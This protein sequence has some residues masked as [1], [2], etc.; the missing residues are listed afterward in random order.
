MIKMIKKIRSLKSRLFI[1]LAVFGPGIVTAVADNDAAGVATYSLVGAKFG[2]SIL[3]VLFVVTV[4]LAITHLKINDAE[5]ASI[6]P[7]AS[8]LE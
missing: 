1:L 6:P 2:Y 8:D 3:I 5:T 7:A 4:L